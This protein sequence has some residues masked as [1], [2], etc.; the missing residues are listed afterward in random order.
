VLQT[1]LAASG[2]DAERLLARSQDVDAKTLLMAST[3]RAVARGAFGAPTF[4]VGDEMFYG[5]DQLRDVEEEI[6]A[7]ASAG[8]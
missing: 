2:L 3:E 4:F 7:R 1:A 5:K 6:V 8:S